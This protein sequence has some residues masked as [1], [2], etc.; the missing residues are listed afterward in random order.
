MAIATTFV[1]TPA[2]EAFTNFDM[3]VAPNFIVPNAPHII[4][5]HG[6]GKACASDLVWYDGADEHAYLAAL[7]RVPFGVQNVCLCFPNLGAS[8]REQFWA[9]AAI[10]ALTQPAFID[11]VEPYGYGPSRLI[12]PGIAHYF[13]LG[14]AHAAR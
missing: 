4:S 9:E 14:S 8:L 11:F 2:A 6:K 5:L 1:A 7:R 13:T 3:V 12:H 10:Y